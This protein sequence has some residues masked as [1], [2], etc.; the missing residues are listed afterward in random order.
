MFKLAGTFW[1]AMTTGIEV[2]FRRSD[3]RP[4]KPWESGRGGCFS[5][6]EICKIRRELNFKDILGTVVTGS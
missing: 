6:F 3:H 2:D 5:L 4:N 1:R